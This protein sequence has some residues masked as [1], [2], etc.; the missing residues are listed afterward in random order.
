MKQLRGDHAAAIKV[1][2]KVIAYNRDTSVSDSIAPALVWMHT[3]TCILTPTLVAKLHP[4][5][6]MTYCLHPTA[7]MTYCHPPSP[8]TRPP[9]MA[10]Q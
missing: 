2:D 9:P 8:I 7:F 3:L 5:A 6:F 4:T 10:L 1:L